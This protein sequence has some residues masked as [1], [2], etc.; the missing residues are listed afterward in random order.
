MTRKPFRLIHASDLHLEQPAYGIREVP[1]HLGDLLRDAPYLAAKQ[2]FDA[3]VSEDAALVVLAGDV[4]AAEMAGPRGWAFLTAHF[5]RLRERGIGVYWA[6]GGR[7]APRPW[8]DELPL[9]PNVRLFSHNHIEEY[10]HE[11]EGAPLARLLGISTTAGQPVR[12]EGFT[13][14]PGGLV[15][16]AVVH[17]QPEAAQL[18]RQGIHYWALGGA[19][20]RTTLLIAPAVAHYPGTPQGRQPAESGPHGCTLVEFDTQQQ[21]RTIPLCTDV[22]RWHNEQVLVDDFTNRAE[23]ETRLRARL[24]ELLAGASGI[25]L[26]VCWRVVGGGPLL[27]QLRRGSLASDLLEGLR[28]EYGRQRPGAWSLSLEVEYLPRLPEQWYEEQ[29]IRGDFLR[30]LRH[31][32]MNPDEPLGLED[33][34]PPKQLAEE[35]KFAITHLDQAARQRVLREAA[36]LGIELL[37]GNEARP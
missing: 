11:H 23:L 5:E 25:D 3:A 6:G 33:Y 16:V 7:E 1:E 34:A 35:L 17:G 10:I 21:A 30:A 2:V 22:L 18:Q 13:A 8:P 15:T 24:G 14:D 36:I 32:E 9:P 19:H 37:S 20:E 12:F 28:K 31:L 4:L 29:T 26:L 27:Q